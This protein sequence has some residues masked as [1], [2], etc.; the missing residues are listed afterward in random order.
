[1]DSLQLPHELWLHVVQHLDAIDLLA[2]S[3]VSRSLHAVASD[4]G[5]WKQLLSRQ[6]RPILDAF[7]EDG[8]LAIEDLAAASAKNFYFRFRRD[9]KRLASLRTGQMLVQV[10]A[11]RLS[12]RGP[13]EV[14]S[15]SSLWRDLRADSRPATY[16]VYDVT[17]FSP[18]H[19]GI[20]LSEA[21]TLRDATEWFEM[22]AHS[23][24]A[25]RRLE[26]LRVVDGLPYDH[27]LDELRAKRRRARRWT[28]PLVPRGSERVVAAAAL[29]G[30]VA[31]AAAAW[32]R[33]W[34]AEL[35]AGLSEAFG[36]ALGVLFVGGYVAVSGWRWARR[37][38]GADVKV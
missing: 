18:L 1:M 31:L 24:A 5:I 10:G 29:A 36:E 20:D 27:A 23:D 37:V 25:L 22:A 15:F 7:F 11:Q 3:R 16:G 21:A 28:Q 17:A 13:H 33:P 34:D 8:R 14:Y 30:S 4:E 32:A 35:E 2:T 19:P 26:T 38:L 6:M 12:G 9:W